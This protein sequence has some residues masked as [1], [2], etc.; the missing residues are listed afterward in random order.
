MKTTK[1]LLLGGVVL[2]LA[3]CANQ[4][5]PVTKLDSPV[6]V[7]FVG[8]ISNVASRASGSQWAEGDKIGI[9]GGNYANIP[10]STG[11]DGSFQ[12]AGSSVGIYFNDT[13]K[14][15]F[16]A[17]Y[18]FSG[19]EGT[20]RDIIHF[21]TLDQSVQ[22]SFNYLWAQAS[23]SAANPKAAFNFTHSMTRLVLRFKAEANNGI[24]ASDLAKGIYSIDGVNVSGSF[25][26]ATGE[27][28][29][30]ENTIEEFQFSS[31]GTADG[32]VREYSLILF[33]QAPGVLTLKAVIAGQ[34]YSC[35][36]NHDFVAGKSYT[37][38]LTV[39]KT[40]LK[41]AASTIANWN[42][43]GS[44]SGEATYTDPFNGHEAVLMR[45]ATADT[46]ALYVATCNIGAS[47]PY[48]AGLYFWWGDTK[49]HTIDDGFDFSASNVTTCN[50]N[51]EAL[52]EKGYINADNNL[53]PE[54]DAAHINWGGKWRMPTHNDLQWMK[55]NC[56]FTYTTTPQ[57]GI[58]LK[59]NST[60]GEV[61]LRGAGIKYNTSSLYFNQCCYWS[62][63]ACDISSNESNWSYNLWYHD[64]IML[65]SS[66]HQRFFG[67]SIRP[68]LSK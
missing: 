6:A 27:A 15:D 66:I 14:I 62:A 47:T 48:D 4:D 57:P 58:I 37:Y 11:G 64:D 35:K 34:E 13:Q 45:E 42:D 46:P 7:E 32:S 19:S 24:S 18:P 63:T 8:G 9:T 40:G 60:G 25:E 49:G 39:K 28:W 22:S 44:Y 17:Y 1:Y 53:L 52:R 41:L 61:F 3:S 43:G 16:T 54:H 67:E 2:A 51:L 30:D 33:P 20:A 59:S 50:N 26:P 21:S 29:V 10:Y 65:F 31:I 5:E 36:L 12:Y 23:A 68:V 38:E 55:D 56:S